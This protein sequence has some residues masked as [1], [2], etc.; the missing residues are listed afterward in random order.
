MD[1]VLTD[2]TIDGSEEDGLG[3]NAAAIHQ[4]VLHDEGTVAKHVY[5]VCEV[6]EACLLQVRSILVSCRRTKNTQER[7]RDIHSPILLL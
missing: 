4:V 2:A 6:V 1:G 7:V 5:K 3:D